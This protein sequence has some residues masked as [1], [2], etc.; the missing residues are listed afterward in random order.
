[1][2]K[3]AI[4]FVSVLILFYSV[5]CMLWGGARILSVISAVSG[6]GGMFREVLRYLLYFLKG[7]VGLVTGFYGIKSVREVWRSSFTVYAAVTAAVF[8]A[9]VM[10]LYGFKLY[11]ILYT[12]LLVLLIV[13]IR[14]GEDKEKE[15]AEETDKSAACLF[16]AKQAMSRNRC[17]RR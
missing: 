11:S 3:R 2:R 16:A 17:E 9:A 8:E 10:I 14:S 5:C 6:E 13:L 7:A 1:M 15:T 4:R 12:G